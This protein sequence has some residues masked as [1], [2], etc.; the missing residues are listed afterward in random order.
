MSAASAIF[1]SVAA[2]FAV[3]PVIGNAELLIVLLLLGIVLVVLGL[4]FAFFRKHVT[5]IFYIVAAGVLY[6]FV[7]TLAKVVI[8]RLFN[9]ASDWLTRRASRLC[10]PRWLSA[11]TS[12]RPRTRSDRRTW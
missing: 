3:E 12:C 8:N 9:G 6:G 7:A 5:A 10:W 4:A 2:V 11:R 1:V